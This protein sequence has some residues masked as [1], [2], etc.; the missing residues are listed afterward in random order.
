MADWKAAAAARGIT[1]TDAQADRIEAL[2]KAMT[3][4]GAMIDWKELPVQ[5]FQIEDLEEAP[6][7]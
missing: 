1:L 6:A 4:M 7:Q 3:L 2:D 5:T